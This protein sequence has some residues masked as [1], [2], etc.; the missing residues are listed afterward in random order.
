LNGYGMALTSFESSSVFAR[1]L[2]KGDKTYGI[3]VDR[4]QWDSQ[5]K[6]FV[7]IEYLLTDEKQFARGVT[8][9]S[10][11][12]NR[13]FWKNS[14]KFISLWEVANHLGAQLFLVN[15]SKKGTEHADEVLLMK[16]RSVDSARTSD[17]VQTEDTRM[18]REGFSSWFR[19]LNKRGS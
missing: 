11:H 14:S 17:P 8:P 10:S 16:V 9:Y 19:R 1:E 5:S 18:T 7:M 6:Q 13:Y 15:Y 3:N 2:L 12:P 4:V